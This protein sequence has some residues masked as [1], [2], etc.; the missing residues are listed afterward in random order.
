MSQEAERNGNDLPATVDRKRNDNDLGNAWR[1]VG[2]Q[3]QQLG[4]KLADALR[5]SWRSTADAQESEATMRKLR[6]DLRAAAD[7]V[8]RV[9]HQ[10]KEETIDER[11]ATMRATRRASEQSLEETRVLTA[12]T[13]RKLNKQLDL[14]AKRLEREDAED[15]A[16]ETYNSNQR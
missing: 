15:R 4:S 12:A 1:E 8:D 2:E 5:K 3:F 16:G 6:D 7:R 9:I 14:L 13:L 10:V 11:T